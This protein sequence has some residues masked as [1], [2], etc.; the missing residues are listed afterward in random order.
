MSDPF[1]P[2]SNA[3]L[4]REARIGL[5]LV[6][7]LFF[8]FVYVAYYRISGQGR[9]IPEHVRRAPVAKP[10]WPNEHVG[11]PRR[12]ADSDS[13]FER[14][15]PMPRP[16]RSPGSDLANRSTSN[17]A[18]GGVNA[19]ARLLSSKSR[20]SF[21]SGFS[22]EPSADSGGPPTR[23]FHPKRTGS[24]TGSLPPTNR[25]ARTQKMARLMD[26]ATAVPGRQRAL[27]GSTEDGNEKRA[28]KLEQVES[29]AGIRRPT[30]TPKLVPE[31]R[32]AADL[33]GFPTNVA[34]D[35]FLAMLATNRET[36]STASV[37]S[38]FRS[39]SGG[40]PDSNEFQPSQVIKASAS[41]AEGEQEFST[42]ADFQ[43]ER[44]TRHAPKSENEF[45][46]TNSIV[47]NDLRGSSTM[48]TPKPISPHLGTVEERAQIDRKPS[49][50]SPVPVE[51]KPQPPLQ[52]SGTKNR[53]GTSGIEKRP[54]FEGFAP[55]SGDSGPTADA[56][57]DFDSGLPELEIVA[58]PS[59]SVQ[60]GTSGSSREADRWKAG[61]DNLLEDFESREGR[62]KL[63]SYPDDNPQNDL[64]RPLPDE[65]TTRPTHAVEGQLLSR[66]AQRTYVA[67]TGDSFWI[68]AQKVYG[69][70][71]FFKALY[72]CNRH[73]VRDF[74]SILSGTRIETPSREELI[75]LW[76]NDC[77]PDVVAAQHST[78]AENLRFR[79]PPQNPVNTRSSIYRTRSGDT[80]FGI[81]REQLSQAS[82]YLE[83][84][85]LNRQR[86]DTDVNHLTPLPEGIE[87]LLP[88]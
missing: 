73:N 24:K 47:T 61:S 17:N 68:I 81:A 45:E 50:F 67:Q 4:I 27:P 43:T 40:P 77:P 12:Y 88:N 71:R 20:T 41:H 48:V 11:A 44:T 60:P 74:N 25:Q 13:G 22:N 5:T 58:A 46:N 84:K 62:T 2:N 78:D 18:R 29:F 57:Q 55:N 70:G 35:P 42:K 54:T 37:S 31:T 32:R 87:L 14:R 15:R 59:E 85:E 9:S 8:V 30:D 38:E 76:P 79:G 7:V 23:D 49:D 52:E 63:P 51:P 39:S 86:L 82:R 83:I 72:A 75:R 19:D 3:Q 33:I 53:T 80:L 65:A 56:G 28:S 1:S 6:A 64:D 21:D 66:P 69:D 36:R 34:D 16:N 26:Q 10:I